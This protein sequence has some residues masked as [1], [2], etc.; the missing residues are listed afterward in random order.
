MAND[1]KYAYAVARVRVLENRL[2]NKGQIDRMTEAPGAREALQV[3]G[4]TDYS[5]AVGELE[6]VHHFED[7]LAAELGRVYGEVRRFYPEPRLIEALA[8]KYDVHNLKVLLKARGMGQELEEDLLYHGVGNISPAKL[9]VMLA[10]EDFRDL[11]PH[12]REAVEEVGAR[13]AQNP[14]PQLID[15][16]LD[17]A[18]YA[19][20]FA[21]I[22]D[23]PFLVEFFTHQANLI[24]LRTLVR[25][26]ILKQKGDFLQ[27]VLLGGSDIDQQLLCDLLS[28]P[29]EALC[30]CFA[31]SPYAQVVE[32][33]LLEWQEKGR[34]TRWEKLAD[35]FLLGFVRQHRHEPFGPQSLLGY[36]LAV[37]NE[38][39]LIRI[40]MVGKLNHLPIEEIRERLRDV[41]V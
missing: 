14:D 41:Y 21:L 23:I 10:T 30:D 22:A 32:E 29:L 3:L 38:L 17:G 36:L 35:D 20:I 31:L 33:G 6:D 5:S 39:K 24:N 28:E 11:A 13:W 9:Q 19:H 1:S 34:L 4:E 7:L 16:L 2:L 27:K 15:I 40:I 8:A 25:L 26:Q 37:E 18:L 12:L